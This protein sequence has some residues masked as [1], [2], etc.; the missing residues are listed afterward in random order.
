[1]NVFSLLLYGFSLE[2]HY[3]HH[4]YVV[5]F[6][7]SAIAG[8]K[9]FLSKGNLACTYL[10]PNDLMAGAASGVYGIFGL[11]VIY[12]IEYYM[13]MNDERQ[14]TVG[15]FFW[16]VG[17][18]FMLYFMDDNIDSKALPVAFLFGLF[19]SFIVSKQCTDRVA[20][21]IKVK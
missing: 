5:I 21:I 1:M 16:V 10:Y 13:Y 2:M 17:S 15:S 12:I 11:Q 18:T 20:K 3:G 19:T 7:S 14:N 9:N 4:I 8:K 6:F